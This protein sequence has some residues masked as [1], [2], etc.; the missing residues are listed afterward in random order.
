[1]RS[2]KKERRS[3]L[4]RMQVLSELAKNASAIACFGAIEANK[5]ASVFASSD[6]KDHDIFCSGAVI[7]FGATFDCEMDAIGAIHDRD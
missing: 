7:N 1:M 6:K 3:K 2:S 4:P 5:T